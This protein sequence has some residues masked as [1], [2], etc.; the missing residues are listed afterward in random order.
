MLAHGG[1]S[2]WPSLKAP[3]YSVHRPFRQVSPEGQSQLALHSRP[4]PVPGRQ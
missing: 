2:R 4:E 3:R 1:S